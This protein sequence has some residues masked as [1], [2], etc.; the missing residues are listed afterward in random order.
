MSAKVEVGSKV[1]K[2]LLF[3][4]MICI[5]VY[6]I[7]TIASACLSWG[8]F[9][10]PLTWTIYAALFLSVT[11][12][13]ALFLGVAAYAGVHA[14][15]RSSRPAS[16]SFL[17]SL[18]PIFLLILL[19][20]KSAFV[21]GAKMYFQRQY[22]SGKVN[23][24]GLSNLLAMCIRE[25]PEGA[26]F[27]SYEDLVRG[28]YVQEDYSKLDDKVLS[29]MQPHYVLFETAPSGRSLTLEWGG[30]ILGRYGICFDE[31][32]GKHLGYKKHVPLS[33]NLFF[34]WK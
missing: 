17:L 3:L 24:N 34:V 11:L 23:E 14:L 16:I 30:S 1:G 28:S 12:Q 20:P 25:V 21:F 13:I 9:A 2:S 4:P 15:R 31:G 26:H 7:I 27:I 32:L 6:L 33:S 8:W 22:I 19:P 29:A 5:S 10:R 18:L